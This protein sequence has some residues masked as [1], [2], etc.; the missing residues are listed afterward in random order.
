MQMDNFTFT[1]YLSGL[2][3]KE[4]KLSTL[5]NVYFPPVLE[6]ITTQDE[7]CASLSM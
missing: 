7:N 2:E 4:H 3:E 6:I 1:L 5:S